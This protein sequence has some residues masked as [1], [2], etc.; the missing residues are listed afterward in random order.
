MA[1]AIPGGWG[2]IRRCVD[3]GWKRP[4]ITVWRVCVVAVRFWMSRVPD[5]DF[6]EVDGAGR[7]PA[8]A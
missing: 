7:G 1:T 3:G 8:G 5:N 6:M 2:E 4:W